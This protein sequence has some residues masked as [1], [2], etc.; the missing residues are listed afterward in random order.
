MHE[1]LTERIFRPSHGSAIADS[2]NRNAHFAL[3]Q[4]RWFELNKTI[5]VLALSC[6]A[7]C[8]ATVSAHAASIS[9]ASSSTSSF[10]IYWS[11]VVGGAELAAVGNFDVTVTD[12]YVDF[13]VTLTNNTVASANENVHSIGFNTDPNGTS[14]SMTDPGHYFTSLGLEQKFPGYK[15]I[16]ICAW[17]SNNC[18][19]GAQER[20]CR[21]RQCRF[22]WISIARRFQ[23]RNRAEYVRVEVPRRLG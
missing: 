16:D 7:W 11:L 3:G 23:Q 12:S 2:S 22:F 1:R 9:I 13:E 6:L 19:G 18:S 5:R 15:T 4:Q 21:R 10:D 17:G 14:L 8:A 20:I